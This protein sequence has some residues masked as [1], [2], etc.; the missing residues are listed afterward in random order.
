MPLLCSLIIQ[1][2]SKNRRQRI[3]IDDVRVLN[4]RI[5]Q[6]AIYFLNDL[7]MFHLIDWYLLALKYLRFWLL[8]L[9][10]EHS[11]WSLSLEIRCHC[12]LRSLSLQTCVWRVFAHHYTLSAWVIVILLKEL[13]IKFILQLIG[14]LIN[15][16]RGTPI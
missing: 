2:L 8:K 7:V 13:F 16:K 12:Y 14:S 9:V 5:I 6:L 15:D 11:L 3:E 4:L 10:F 1:K